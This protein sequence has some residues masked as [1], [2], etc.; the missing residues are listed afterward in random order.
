MAKA[1]AHIG[2][3]RRAGTFWGVAHV[4]GMHN[5]LGASQGKKAKRKN[6]MKI[7]KQK[8]EATNLRRTYSKLLGS[9]LTSQRTAAMIKATARAKSLITALS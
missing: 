9:F 8:T 2:V 6:D 5:K 1:V 3:K 4:P 7:G